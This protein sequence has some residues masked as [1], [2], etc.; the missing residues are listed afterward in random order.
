[1]WDIPWH[2]EKF[3][4]NG[5]H[6]PDMNVLDKMN[7]NWYIIEGTMCMPGKIPARAMLKRDKYADLRLGVKSLYPGNK[8]SSV[9]VVFDFLP[10]HSINL[11][12]ELADSLQ[13]KKAVGVTIEK[14]Q[15]WMISQNCEIV[16]WFMW[17]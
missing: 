15:K 6:K 3:P 10:A 17:E 11:T 8:V 4:R 14:A 7:K 1:M 12:K 9:P 13:N 2:L 16:K 5:T